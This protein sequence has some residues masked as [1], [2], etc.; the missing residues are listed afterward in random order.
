MPASRYVE[1]I[2]PVAMLPIKRSAG[3]APMVN[4]REYV[5]FTFTSL[6]SGNKAAHSGFETQ[7]RHHQKSEMVVSG[8][9]QKCSSKYLR[10]LSIHSQN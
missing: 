8:D 2:E 4:L 1:D 7:M 10:G 5:T 6:P 3:V 9:P